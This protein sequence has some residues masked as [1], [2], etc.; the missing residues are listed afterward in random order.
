MR[1]TLIHLEVKD[2]AEGENIARALNDP[3][4]RAFVVIV[5]ALLP[6]GDRARTRVLSFINDKVNE[7]LGRVT[8]ESHGDLHHAQ[9]RAPLP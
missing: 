9:V 8:I 2:K 6:L 1:R 7:D 4:T 5:G 3:M